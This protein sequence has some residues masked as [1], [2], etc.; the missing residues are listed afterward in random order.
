MFTANDCRPANILSILLFSI[1][2]I[3]FSVTGTDLLVL[4]AMETC[5]AIPPNVDPIFQL[6]T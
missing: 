2:S 6:W 3:I 1:S 5:T 4:L